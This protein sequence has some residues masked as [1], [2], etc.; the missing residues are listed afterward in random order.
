LNN[1]GYD[2]VTAEAQDLKPFIAGLSRSE[3]QMALAACLA[4]FIGIISQQGL[5]G[6]VIAIAILCLLA[7]MIF[8]QFKSGWPRATLGLAVI[9]G[10]AWL[11]VAIEPGLLNLTMMWGSLA[12]FALVQQGVS[13]LNLFRLGKTVLTTLVQTPLRFLGELRLA[14]AIRNQGRIHPRLMTIANLL[15]PLVAITVFGGLLMVANPLI[16]SAVLQISWGNSFDIFLSWLLPVTVLAFLLVWAILKI[17]PLTPEEAADQPII[18]EGWRPQYFMPVP[19]ILTLLILNSMFLVETLLDLQY[20]WSGTSLPAGL[21]YAEYVHRGSYTLI[22]TAILAG[23]LVIFALQPG[24]RSEESQPVRWLV[25]LW[26]FQNVFLVASSA[27]RTLSYVDAYGMT[28]W[29]LSGLIWMGLVATGLIFI[30]ARVITKRSN[31]WLTNVN[32]GAAF[33]LL[34]VCGLTDFRGFVADWNVERA[35]VKIDPTKTYNYLDIDSDYLFDLG[36]SALPSIHRLKKAADTSP[37]IWISHGYASSIAHG[38]LNRLNNQLLARQ[39]DWKTW[40]L[41]GVWIEYVGGSA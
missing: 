20:V 3:F 9:N 40:T 15:L 27:K 41:R 37:K 13:A 35:L 39:S 10:L 17:P 26:T 24:S 23:A 1:E 11:A 2:A 12:G 29:R 5:P 33:A 38:L 36:P 30:M 19:V 18:S 4:L 16:E 7:M 34:L 28:L 14:K 21:N 22:A 32:L 31:L 25:Y 6:S 8:N